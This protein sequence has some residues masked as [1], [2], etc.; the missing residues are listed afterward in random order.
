MDLRVTLASGGPQNL[1]HSCRYLCVYNRMLSDWLRALGSTSELCDCLSPGEVFCVSVSVN[2][3]AFGCVLVVRVCVY[4][5]VVASLWLQ[6][7]KKSLTCCHT[8]G[9]PWAIMISLK[10]WMNKKDRVKPCNSSSWISCGGNK[11]KT[12]VAVYFVNEMDSA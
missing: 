3:Q 5:H 7:C 11:L 2:F 4:A 10:C 8:L 12:P 6:A 1:T 9:S